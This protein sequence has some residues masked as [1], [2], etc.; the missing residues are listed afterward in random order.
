[1]NTLASPPS[2]PA[3][4]LTVA[5]IRRSVRVPLLRAAGATADLVTFDGLPDADDFALVFA[6]PTA[7]TVDPAEVPWV[8]VHSSCVTGDVFGSCRCDCGPQLDRALTWLAGHGGCL[9][10]LQQEGRGIGLRA[11]I[12]AYAMQDRGLDTYAANAALGLPL[13][14]RTYGGAAAMLNAL[15]FSRIRLLSANPEKRR[16]LAAHGI[17]VVDLQPISI[18]ANPFNRDYLAAKHARFDQYRE[19]DPPD[20]ASGD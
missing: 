7:G 17:D 15:G 5:S 1:M 20:V 12:D 2:P 14:A 18:A 16:Q 6:P 9:L 11:K 8:R 13:D 4:L 3:P 19:S 10:Y